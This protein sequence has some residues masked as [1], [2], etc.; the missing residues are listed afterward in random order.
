MPEEPI[1]MAHIVVEAPDIVGKQVQ[2]LS[3]QEARQE[4][5]RMGWV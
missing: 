1:T 2:A 3:L 5:W 4:T